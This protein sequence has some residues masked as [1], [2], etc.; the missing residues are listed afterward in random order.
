MTRKATHRIR[1]VLLFAAALSLGLHCAV[2]QVVGW[3]NMAVEFSGKASWSEALVMTFDG[4]HPCELCKLVEQEMNQPD[5]DQ[6][7]A[8]ESKAELKLPPV[9]CWVDGIR[10]LP[11]GHDSLSLVEQDDRS[12]PRRE[13]PP[14]PPPRTA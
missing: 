5:S 10:L 13:R 12:R 9:V 3:A 11:L 1:L 2:M 6:K 4:K 14:L 7:S 8:P